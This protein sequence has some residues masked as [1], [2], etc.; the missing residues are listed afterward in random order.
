[1]PAD[2]WKLLEARE[3]HR[4]PW[5]GVLEQRFEAHGRPVRYF[6]V[7]FPRPAVGVVPCRGDEVLLIRQY[8]VLIDQEVWAIPSGSV[9]EGETSQQAAARE[10]SEETGFTAHSLQHLVRYHPSYGSGN[11]VFETFSAHGL[12]QGEVRLDPVE[13]LDTRWFSWS[14]IRQV[15]LGGEITDGLSLVPLMH[16]LMRGPPC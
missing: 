9:D 4:N 5:F 10:L 7:D 12:E 6:G 16:L 15:V 14:H 11:Q 3:V 8:R 13:V 1:M 2:D